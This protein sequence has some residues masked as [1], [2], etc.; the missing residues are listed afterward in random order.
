M[1]IK[2]LNIKINEDGKFS[3]ID[4]RQE[5]SLYKLLKFLK[6]NKNIDTLNVRFYTKEQ[7]ITDK[8]VKLFNILCSKIATE[9]G[10]DFDSIKIHLIQNSGFSNLE[11][12]ND[13]FQFLL[14][15]SIRIAKEFYN[16][17]LSIDPETNH[18]E[19]K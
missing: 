15:N 16:I 13:Q 12:N 14:E 4:L 9:A 1:E 3:F 7:T 18:I 10:D 17:D 8:Q 2:S 6:N 5:E 19:I 11:L